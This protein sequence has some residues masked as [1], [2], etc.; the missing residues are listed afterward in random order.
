MTNTNFATSLNLSR[1]EIRILQA[2]TPE[3]LAAIKRNLRVDADQEAIDAAA[4]YMADGGEIS[5]ISGLFG[6]TTPQEKTFLD[7]AEEAMDWYRKE[8]GASQTESYNAWLASQRIAL[9]AYLAEHRDDCY[10]P[11]AQYEA[12]ALKEMAAKAKG[13]N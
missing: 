13:G 3:Q 8:T 5:D 6:T 12:E 1:E 10:K 9:D 11:L 4:Q 2:L 7:A